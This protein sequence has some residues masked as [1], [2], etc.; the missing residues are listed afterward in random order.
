MQR[1][2]AEEFLDS[3][4]W[5]AEEVACALGA[6]RRVNQINGGDWMH[7]RLFRRII[8]RLPANQIDIL[9]VASARGEVIQATAR[10]LQRNKIS[11]RISLLDRSDM[12][13]PGKLDWDPSLPP[14]NLFVGDALEIPLPDHSV[15]VVSCCL[16]FHHLGEQQ[17]RRFLQEALRVCRVAVLVN[18]VERTRMNYFLS[19]L[20]SLVD[21]S[22]LSQ[23]DGPT[24]V[25]QAYTFQ[26]LK[27][28]LQETGSGF[29]LRRG[30]LYRLGAILWKK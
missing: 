26:E 24:S 21:P 30:F 11:V 5:S 22:E 23:H 16:F 12:H 25:C 19:R 3:D 29:E 6:I 15:D 10:M 8:S 4:G 18:D 9:E 14:P 13:L 20:Y 2:E 27:N 17:A 28:M 1:V 7:K